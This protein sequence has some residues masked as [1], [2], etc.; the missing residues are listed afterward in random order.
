MRP[1][2]APSVSRPHIRLCP[3]RPAHRPSP[4]R[5]L[6]T[7]P[8]LSP[9]KPPM[10]FDHSHL[11]PP[12][13]PVRN[14]SSQRPPNAHPVATGPAAPS[15][16]PVLRRRL[17]KSGQYSPGCASLPYLHSN[18]IQFKSHAIPYTS[19]CRRSSES[20]SEPWSDVKLLPQDPELESPAG[21]GYVQHEGSRAVR[22][23]MTRT[24]SSGYPRE[25]R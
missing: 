5:P 20:L 9:H 22:R 8:R 18:P 16:V 6:Q 1:L 25:R 3:P 21:Q 17:P 7:P 2:F 11:R 23:A 10:S 24:A 15:R 19:R 4:S 14:S 12:S 13:G